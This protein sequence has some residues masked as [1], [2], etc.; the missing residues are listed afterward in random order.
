MTRVVPTLYHVI[1]LPAEVPPD[2][3]RAL[4]R[5]QV[6]A[7]RLHTCVVL[8]N[9]LG[10]YLTPEGGETVVAGHSVRRHPRC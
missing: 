1:L 5:S 3:L 10:L 4:A 9:D 6:R 7:N 8:G 2:G